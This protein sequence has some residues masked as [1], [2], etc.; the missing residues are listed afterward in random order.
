MGS[1][2][3]DGGWMVMRSHAGGWWLAATVN[4]HAKLITRQRES[5]HA[6]SFQ[7]GL[8]I[9]LTLSSVLEPKKYACQ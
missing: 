8:T 5:P 4:T 7:L 2:R 3:M 1:K 9:M 6:L